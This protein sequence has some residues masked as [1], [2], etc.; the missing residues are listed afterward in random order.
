M[1]YSYDPRAPQGY[2][3]IHMIR[4][5]PKG[6]TRAPQG[7]HRG[8]APSDRKKGVRL[9]EGG[10]SKAQSHAASRPIRAS[11]NSLRCGNNPRWVCRRLPGGL[12]IVSQKGDLA[13]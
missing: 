11:C 13:V 1:G 2:T 10:W 8:T 6:Y 12:M 9:N 4:V 3:D 5:R 7:V